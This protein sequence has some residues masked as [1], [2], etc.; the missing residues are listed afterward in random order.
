MPQ[1]WFSLGS[2]HFDII[3]KMLNLASLDVISVSH[4]SYLASAV[5]TFQS[6]FFSRQEICFFDCPCFS[7]FSDDTDHQA[8]I[9]PWYYA[10]VFCTHTLTFFADDTSW[11]WQLL[12]DLDDLLQGRWCRIFCLGEVVTPE[13]SVLRIFPCFFAMIILNF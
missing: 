13:I 2:H 6:P 11:R 12:I 4:I 5:F 9:A 3:L 10:S 7:L 8:E 1:L